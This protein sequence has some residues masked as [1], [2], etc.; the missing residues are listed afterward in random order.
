MM[1]KLELGL[2]LQIERDLETSVPLICC[3]NTVLEAQKCRV[4]PTKTYSNL[5][6]HKL[7]CSF[8]DTAG[9][10]KNLKKL[11]FCFSTLWWGWP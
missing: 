9:K 2:Y 6:H 7:E 1:E 4:T 3:V 10:K 8:P 11:C 5:A